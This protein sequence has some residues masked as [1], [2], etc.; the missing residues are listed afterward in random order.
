MEVMRCLKVLATRRLRRLRR[1][2]RRKS[3]KKTIVNYG[4]LWGIKWLS[5]FVLLIGIALRSAGVYPLLDLI[6]TASGAAG[7]ALVA[8]RWNDRALLVINSVALVLLLVGI[9]ERTV[10]DG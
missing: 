7:W 1:N 2:R 9:L 3:N 8:Y 6:L 4:F 5:T 10:V